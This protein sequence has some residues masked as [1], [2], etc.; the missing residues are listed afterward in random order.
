MFICA[1][2]F[3]GIED[4]E[5]MILSATRVQFGSFQ[6]HLVEDVELKPDNLCISFRPD[7]AATENMVFVGDPQEFVKTIYCCN[8]TSTTILFRPIQKQLKDIQAAING[9][10]DKEKGKPFIRWPLLQLLLV[11]AGD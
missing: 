5:G 3:T 11:L 1:Y 4:N 2:P 8:E 6:V 9:P 10:A 7:G